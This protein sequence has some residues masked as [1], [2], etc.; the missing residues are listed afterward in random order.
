MHD[1]TF[2]NEHFLSRSSG[3]RQ[4][5]RPCHQTAGA[6]NFSRHFQCLLVGVVHGQSQFYFSFLLLLVIL[7]N[8]IRK[9]DA[10]TLEGFSRK[11]SKEFRN[12]RS[13]KKRN[14]PKNCQRVSYS[15]QGRDGDRRTVRERDW[16][17]GS[18][19]GSL[20]I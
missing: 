18:M 13:T 11:T 15:L 8:S 20:S 1:V 12:G 7:K 2:F 5:R 4:R 19:E 17:R 14:F 3:R 9:S 6:W 16:K 10:R